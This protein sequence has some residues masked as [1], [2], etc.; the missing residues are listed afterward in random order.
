V[1]GDA[2]P[3]VLLD[4]LE[5]G[6]GRIQTSHHHQRDREG[7]QR[8]PQRH[9]ARRALA[10]GSLPRTSAMNSAPTSGRKV[11][12]ERIGQVIVC[13]RYLTANMNQVMNIAAPISMAKA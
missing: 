1:V 9:P 12:T 3:G 8:G 4:E 6:R 11:T 5:F 2:E 13:F 7:H 10:K